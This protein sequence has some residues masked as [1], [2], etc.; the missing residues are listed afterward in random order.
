MKTESR[1]ALG[2]AGLPQRIRAL[3]RGSVYAIAIDRRAVR[4]RL[5]SRSV[6]DSLAAGLHV[7]LVIS[8]EN[9]RHL[10]AALGDSRDVG[11]LHVVDAG[12]LASR[13]QGLEVQHAIDECAAR[14]PGA[15]GLIAFDRADPF[16]G[17]SHMPAADAAAMRWQ[18][19]ASGGGHTVLA[20]FDAVAGPAREFSALESI[21]AGFA[22]FGV[23][24]TAGPQTT[25]DLRHWTGAVGVT[26]R[27]TW[28]LHPDAADDGLLADADLRSDGRVAMPPEPE[29]AVAPLL[30][31]TRRAASDLATEPP[32]WRV[33]PGWDDAVQAAVQA[34]RQA[35]VGALLL[36]FHQPQDLLALARAIAAVRAQPGGSPAIVVRETGARLRIAQQVALLRIGAS[37]IV[38][39]EADPVRVRMAVE[40]FATVGGLSHEVDV[41]VER[42]LAEVGARFGGLLAPDVF[43]QEVER[44]L[45]GTGDELQHALVRLDALGEDVQRLARVAARRS[46]DTVLCAD[47]HGLWMFLFGCNADEVDVVLPRLFGAR[48]E[49]LFVRRTASGTSAEIRRALATISRENLPIS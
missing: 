44:L 20:L 45:G 7:L 32:G 1:P 36:H 16:F 42:V 30:V 38:S 49:R 35:R 6:R 9:W 47:R 28:L 29:P 26:R 2:I 19:W 41:D 11:R 18:A 33:V 40:S 37:L 13:M 23:V 14:L 5:L 3:A 21:A 15:G 25:F 27:T 46:R 39:R 12:A 4:Q 48:F 17:L 10:S 34:A 43:G 31:A 24:R 8:A 22:G